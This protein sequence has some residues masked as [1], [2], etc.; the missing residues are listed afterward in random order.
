MCDSEQSSR[1]SEDVCDALAA[2]YRS[3]NA[4][5]L[6]GF[7]LLDLEFIILCVVLFKL[8]KRGQFKSLPSNVKTIFIALLF[9]TLMSLSFWFYLIVIKGGSKVEHFFT[10]QG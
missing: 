9:Y 1:Y 10:I 7:Y 2:Y 6:T 3:N 4:Y 5:I 8:L